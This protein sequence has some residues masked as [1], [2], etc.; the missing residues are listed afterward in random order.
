MFEYSYIIKITAF[1]FDK[2]GMIFPFAQVFLKLW[3]T[4]DH[5]VNEN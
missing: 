5:N 2:S 3:L 1:E 4:G